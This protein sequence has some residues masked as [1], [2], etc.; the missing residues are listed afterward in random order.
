MIP[1]LLMGGNAGA[2]N[3]RVAPPKVVGANEKVGVALIGIGNRGAEVAKEFRKT[4]LCDVV[5]L[6]DVDMGAKHTQEIEAMF[7]GVPKYRDFRK[8]FDEMAGRID[9]VMVATPDTAISRSAWPPCGRVFTSTW[10]SRWPARFTS[11]NC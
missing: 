4:G 7:P 10:R 1:S 8:L 3:K 6:C 9:A 11:A 5:A 2:G